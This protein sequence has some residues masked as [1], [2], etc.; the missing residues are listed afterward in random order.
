MMLLWR[1]RTGTPSKRISPPW[2]SS[3]PLTQRSSV[4]LPV[5]EGPMKQTISPGLMAVEMP[6]STVR[7][8]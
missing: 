2:I 7:V 3:R 5:P 8:P 4:D 6:S 1:A